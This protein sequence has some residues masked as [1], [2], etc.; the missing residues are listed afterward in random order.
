MTSTTPPPEP[1]A[2]RR[3]AHPRPELLDIVPQWLTRKQAA[4][5][6]G[7]TARTIDRW[8]ADGK[9]STYRRANGTA[10][11]PILVSRDDLRALLT[12]A[13]DPAETTPKQESDRAPS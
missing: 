10:Y 12:V 9:L 1:Q 11:K 4:K 7:V 2:R 13:P 8:R 3:A 5:I 6:A